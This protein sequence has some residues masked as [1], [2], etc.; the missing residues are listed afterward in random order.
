LSSLFSKK[1]STAGDSR[2]TE[3]AHPVFAGAGVPEKDA[4]EESS[5][6]HPVEPCRFGACLQ[7]SIDF[8]G[9]GCYNS[10]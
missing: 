10:R 3:Y 8:E 5:R 1:Y 7:K 6:V 4:A 2:G 9:G